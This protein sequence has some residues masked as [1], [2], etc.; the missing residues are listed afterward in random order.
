MTDAAPP[1]AERMLLRP[2]S[3]RLI[4]GVCAGVAR[5]LGWDATLV[6]ALWVL[7][8]LCLGLGALLYVGL[9][10]AIPQDHER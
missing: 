2:R 9:W 10:L 4:A 7:L 8:T 5:A 3:G 6:R 1:A